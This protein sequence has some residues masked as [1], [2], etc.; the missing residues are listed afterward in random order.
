MFIVTFSNRKIYYNVCL[1]RQE[2]DSLD[3]IG[4]V[5]VGLLLQACDKH[6]VALSHHSYGIVTTRLVERCKLPRVQCDLNRIK[7]NHHHIYVHCTCTCMHTCT[8]IIVCVLLPDAA[9]LLT[10]MYVCICGGMHGG[11]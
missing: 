2:G 5:V 8:C 7:Y 10:N 1:I 3:A 11:Y 9:P 4:S 6:V